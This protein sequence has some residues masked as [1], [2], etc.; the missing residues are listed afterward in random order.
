MTGGLAFFFTRRMGLRR[1]HN[2]GMFEREVALYRRLREHLDDVLFVTDDDLRDLRFANHPHL[3][4]IEVACNAFRLPWPVA[5]RML[6]LGHGGTLAR[7][8]VFKS[9]Q[10]PGADRGLA[11]AR[12]YGKPFIA[13][14]GYLHAQFVRFDK[15]PDAPETRA[16]EAMERHVFLGADRVVVTTGAMREEIMRDYGLEAARIRVIPNYVDT[17]VFRPLLP[18]DERVARDVLFVGRL[19]RQKNL[20]VLL[21][22]VAGTD[23]RLHLV[24]QG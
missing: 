6:M 1:W 14:C 5:D 22:A 21:R 4:G 15:G 19:N 23:L 18:A 11:L 12:R 8:G 2:Y 7:A 24:G 10:V 9:N 20:P 13:R 17:D 3:K 16:A